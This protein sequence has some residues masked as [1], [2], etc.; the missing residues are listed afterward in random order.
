MR[1]LLASAMTVGL[2]AG[3]AVSAQ[4][5]DPP[6]DLSKVTRIE[7]LAF[8]RLLQMDQLLVI[9]VRDAESYR[10]GHIPGA[11]SV[12]LDQIPRRAEELRGSK[13]PI[14]TYCS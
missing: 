9:D 3:T 6:D 2:L 7:M 12:P 5:Q 11:V 14:V 10:L 4:P 13:K 1:R 8:S